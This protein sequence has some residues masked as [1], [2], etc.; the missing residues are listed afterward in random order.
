MPAATGSAGSI[1]R[2]GEMIV[3]IASIVTAALVLLLV[4]YWLYSVQV[5]NP[6]VARE[7]VEHPD[8]ER[9]R[10][11]MLL[12]LPSGRRIPVNY[13][14]EGAVVYAAADGRWWRE[15]VG[16]GFPVTLLVRGEAL[17]GAARA[18]LADPGHTSDVFKRLR[19]NAIEGFGTLVEI[20]LDEAGRL[21]PRL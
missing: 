12:T 17:R 1:A 6:R 20:R 2:R 7:L 4:G 11:V 3:R 13:L 5:A 18:V 10:R 14:R 15:L 9:A 19:P 8:G 16:D 21:P